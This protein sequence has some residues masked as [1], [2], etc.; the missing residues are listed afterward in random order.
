M[1]NLS[2]FW[3]YIAQEFIETDMLGMYDK[4]PMTLKFELFQILLIL[5]AFWVNLNDL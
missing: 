5:V 4:V 3:E 1:L 2:N